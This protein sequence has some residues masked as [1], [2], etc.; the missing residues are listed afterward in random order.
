MI[1]L[2]SDTGCGFNV[3]NKNPT[4]CINDLV[5]QYNIQ[6]ST[7]LQPFT[8]EHLLASTITHMESLIKLFQTEGKQ[9]F[10]E[11]YYDKWLHRYSSRSMN[12]HS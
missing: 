9:A 1:I 7:H 4:V 6:N 2:L 8:I 12:F 5:Q 3:S 10:L 11:L